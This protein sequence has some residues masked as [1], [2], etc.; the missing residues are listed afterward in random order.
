MPRPASTVPVKVQIES[1]REWQKL[2]LTT[3]RGILKALKRLDVR[4]GLAVLAVICLTI[5]GVF[6]YFYMKYAGIV[7]QRI[8]RPIFNDAAQ[9]YAAA[10]RVE[11][12]D[13]W[14][15]STIIND[16]RKA[17]YISSASAGESTEGAYSQRGNTIEIR[18]GKAS[19]HPG[20]DATLHI[21]GGEVDSIKGSKGEKLSYYDLEPQL[22]TG[23][24]DAKL[25]SKRR[26]LT[27]PEIPA[28]VRNAIVSVEDRRFFEHG[29]I[30]YV[31]LLEGLLEPV[32]H[33][34]RIQGGS[35]LTM[36][37]ARGFFL[38]N[39]R[40]VRRKLAEMMI[41]LVLER[42]FTKE[43]ILEIYV[44]QVDLGQHGSFNIRGFGEGAQ[45]YFGK[46]IKSLTLPEAALL[47]GLVNG[48]TYFSPFRHPPRA[49]R[50]RDIVLQAMYENHAI[51][52]EQLAAAKAT[53]LKLAPPN[54]EA[55][56]APYYVDL[57]RDQLLSQYDESDL[58]NGGMQIY[59]ALDPQLQRAAS[60]AIAIG[61]RQVDQAIIRRRTKK[62][63]Q[64]KGKNATVVTEITP[65]PMPQVAL[66]AMDPH[67]GEVLA[68][69][70]GRDYSTSQLDHAVAKRPTGSIFKPFVYAAAINT[71]LNGDPAKAYTQTTMLDATQGTFDWDG[72]PYSPKNF[73]AKYSVGEVTSRFALQHS[74]NTATI[75]LAQMVGYDKVV[76]LA[77]AAGDENVKPTPAMA[78]GAYDATLLQ[79]A[80]AY[81]VFSNDGVRQSPVF[82][83]SVRNPNV[84]EMQNPGEP[85]KTNVLDSRVAFVITD[86]L[87]AVLNGGTASSV[88]A[89]FSAPA[90]GKTGTSHDAWFAGYTSNLLCLVW[91]GNDDYSDIK[92]E[93]GKAAA[94]IW[95]EFMLRAQ[96]LR[97]YHDMTP[98]TPPPGVVQVHLDK[99]TNLPADESCPDD[100]DAYFVDGTVPAATCD[101]PNGPS[102]NFFQKLFGIGVHRELVL[103]PV[104]PNPAPSQPSANNPNTPG[105]P[106]TNAGAPN[107]TPTP[108]VKEKKRGFWKRLFGGG[109]KD[110]DQN[111]ETTTSDTS[112]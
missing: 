90:A 82:I 112:H 33:H 3:W 66:I 4:I 83:R 30:N 22:V 8:R 62:I 13:E 78:I 20:Q 28:I 61:M 19:Y 105:Q 26:L 73:D 43:Q 98:F 70:G 47:A 27:Y 21:A 99:L 51:T 68:L 67:T 102:R 79:M 55:D 38:S 56:D 104:T 84:G 81:T 37:M 64:G 10:E 91:V 35:T 85:T 110:K 11:V 46:D 2:L 15:T 101:H 108:P 44:N 80:E 6:A 54:V 109:K 53:P 32:L 58:N 18:P 7:D 16:L 29:G 40:S 52:K 42:R 24:F 45:A 107:T 96:K 48:P 77:K 49:I 60:E 12:G 75:R 71:A 57:V 69:A 92:M 86:M 31:R 103:P 74:I 1:P 87:E 97:R 95:T 25:R 14:T 72:K 41:A 5:A 50:R 65:G 17:G 36:Q 76:A 23:M 59:T 39:E 34:R 111:N 89:R 94:P 106:S 100:Y 88:R 9:I 93:G 63:R